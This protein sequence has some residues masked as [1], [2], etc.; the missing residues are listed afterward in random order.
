MKQQA[1][2]QYSRVFVTLSLL[3]FCVVLSVLT[4]L[5]SYSHLLESLPQTILIL[6]YIYLGFIFVRTGFHLIF[7]FLW[8]LHNKKIEKN[9][10]HFPLV[11]IIVPCF[12]EEKV[13]ET[14]LRS[15]FKMNYPNFEIIVVDDGSKDLTFTLARSLKSTHPFRVVFQQNAGKAAALNRGIEEA[16]G[17]YVFCMDADSRLNPDSITKGIRH[18]FTIPNLSA[19]AGNVMIGG[20][21]GLVNSFQKL[22]Y[23]TALNFLKIAQSYL[24]IVTVVPGPVGLFKKSKLLETGGYKT[25]TFAEDCDLTLSLLMKG[26]SVVYEPEMI[27]VTEAPQEFTSLIKQRYRWS[28]G[29]VQA[30]KLNSKWM[31]S[32]ASNIRNFLIMWY[33]AIESLFIPCCNYLF[34]VTA[35]YLA[36]DSSQNFIIGFYFFQLLI[37]DLIIVVYSLIGQGLS[38]NLV[39]L[40]V[41]NRFTYGLALE[42]QR[43]FSV[44][45]E[46]MELPMTWDKLKRNGL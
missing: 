35:L 39:L 7:S 41:V 40:G 30:I 3:V 17:E 19:V 14:A 34:A 44:I 15:L 20:G 9:L 16:K 27:A 22:E 5:M 10:D 13:I 31:I 18:F 8:S 26:G 36:L 42:I 43:F 46:F 25:D 23:I 2:R 38:L 37:L 4:A 28:R 1:G 33:M 6:M 45:D 24:G 32:P 21:S 12:D 29:I 11:S